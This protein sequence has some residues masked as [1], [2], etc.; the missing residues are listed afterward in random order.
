MSFANRPPAQNDLTTLALVRPGTSLVAIE[1][2][3]LNIEFQ[4][5]GD[6]TQP[7]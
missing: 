6:F 4:A 1:L 5:A 7:L 3:V 2:T